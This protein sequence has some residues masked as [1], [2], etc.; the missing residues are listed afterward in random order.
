MHHVS[1]SR[2]ARRVAAGGLG[3]A[4]AL[5]L[6]LP[7]ATPTFAAPTDSPCPQ[8]VTLQC[9]ITFGNARIDQRTTACERARK[10][11][12]SPPR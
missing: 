10:T 4:L 12:A 11:P 1:F 3:V 5:A 6:L 8:P 9:V 2:L 7:G